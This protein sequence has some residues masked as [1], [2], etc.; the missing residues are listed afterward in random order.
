M[1]GEVYRDLVFVR[2]YLGQR[3]IHGSRLFMLKQNLCEIERG[4]AVFET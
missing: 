3:E 4:K 2:C 1:V